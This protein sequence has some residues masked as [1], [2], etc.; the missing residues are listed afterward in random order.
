MKYHH[1]YSFFTNE[2]V[3]C[4]ASRISSKRLLGNAFLRHRQMGSLAGAAHLLNDNADVPRG[5]HGEQ[6]S[7][8][9]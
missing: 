1:L 4:D 2:E 5:T 8:V 9:E 7:P 3:Q 6:K